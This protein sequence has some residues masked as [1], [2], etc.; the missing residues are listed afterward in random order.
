[1]QQRVKNDPAFLLKLQQAWSPRRSTKSIFGLDGR[2][3][4]S[5]GAGNEPQLEISSVA[6]YQQQPEVYFATCRYS[7]TSFT[8]L[9]YTCR[10][11]TNTNQARGTFKFRNGSQ[12]QQIQ[13]FAT[14]VRCRMHLQYWQWRAKMMVPI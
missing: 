3:A 5:V 2:A 1:M 7:C 9:A 14:E 13:M 4:N 11:I 10:W 6:M 12:K 8:I